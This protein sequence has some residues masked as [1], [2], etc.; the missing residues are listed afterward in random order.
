MS[1][2]S[3]RIEQELTA[4][5]NVAM[6]TGCIPQLSDDDTSPEAK[7]AIIDERVVMHGF[8]RGNIIGA[9]GTSIFDGKDYVAGLVNHVSPAVVPDLDGGDDIIQKGLRG[10]ASIVV[11]LKLSSNISVPMRACAERMKLLVEG[12]RPHRRPGG[13]TGCQNSCWPSR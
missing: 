12:D 2:R 5:K 6:D 3:Q 7:R 8:Q 13:G 10:L 1:E 11:A 4:Y 9:D